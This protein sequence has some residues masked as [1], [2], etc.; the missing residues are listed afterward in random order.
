MKRS[1]AT[2]IYSKKGYKKIENKIKL[3]GITDTNKT[4]EFLNARLILCIL[5]FS[6]L[7]VYSKSGFILAPLVTLLVYLGF[8]YL[9]L[10]N[11]IA[12]RQRILENEAIYFFEVLAL[13]IE[14]G[15]NLK[16]AIE[17]TTR[18]IDNE[19]SKEFKRAISEVD[20]GKSL[21]E[22]LD[23]M[24]KRIPSD[25]INNAVLNITQSNIFGSSIINSL[26]NQIDFLRE[27]QIQDIKTEIVKLPTK[28]SA[29]SVV[30]FVPIMLLLILAPVV[31]NYILG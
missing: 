14:S 26:Y 20:M 17:V 21:S 11:R 15:R 7:L 22:A 12:K 8:E 4:E 27:K 13:T 6:I 9:Y 2:R 19:I 31:L 5:V 3:L 18:A 1:F 24:K 30:F 29:V 10:D 25:S 23:N 28:I 16:G